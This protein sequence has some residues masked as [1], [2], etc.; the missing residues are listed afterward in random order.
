VLAIKQTAFEFMIIFNKT[1]NLKNVY[2][3]LAQKTDNF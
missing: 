1:A 2:L 3:V